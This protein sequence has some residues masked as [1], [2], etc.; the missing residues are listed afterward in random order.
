MRRL[1]V[2]LV[3][4]SLLLPASTAVA[5]ETVTLTVSVTNQSGD[6]VGDATLNATWDGGSTERTTAGNGKAFVDVP[7]GTEVEITIDH[8]D[9]V[10]NRPV[11][12]TA[13]S[14]TSP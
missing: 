9:Y 10:R 5:Q 1:L 4:A 7:A 12:V 3:V 6:A 8:P 14:D 2:V 11:T 13:N